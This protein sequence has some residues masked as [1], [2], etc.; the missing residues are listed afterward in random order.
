MT[1]TIS[2]YATYGLGNAAYFGQGLIGAN[3]RTAQMGVD[4]YLSKRTNLYVAAGTF[5]QSSN[6]S[7]AGAAIATA[8]G[9]GG[10]GT[11]GANYALGLRHTF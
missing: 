7:N 5:N 10:V 9:N 1:P 2:A 6:G 4:Y 3:F 11:S 8:S